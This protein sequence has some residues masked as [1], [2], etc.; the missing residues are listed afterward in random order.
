MESLDH[1]VQW[2]RGGQFYMLLHGG[3]PEPVILEL[4]VKLYVRLVYGVPRMF[5]PYPTEHVPIAP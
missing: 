1:A 3:L 5:S 2:I 4:G